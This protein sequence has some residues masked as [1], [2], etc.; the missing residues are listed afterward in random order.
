MTGSGQR[1]VQ[2]HETAR[3]DATPA[4]RRDALRNRQLLLDAAWVLTSERGLDVSYEEIAHAAGT[5]VGTMYRRFPDR[6]DLLDALFAEHVM[7][8]VDL[9]TVAQQSD[10][11]WAG[12]T[13]FLEAQ[14]S[15]EARHQG[16]GQLLRGRHR[17]T[18]VV[19]QAHAAMTPVISG[20]VDRAITAG[21]LPTGVSTAD[22]AAVHLM[23]G[24][25]LDASPVDAR[26]NAP[27]TPIAPWRRA[28]AVA[29]A[30][31]QHADLPGKRPNDTAVDEMYRSEPS[32]LYNAPRKKV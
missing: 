7:Q 16:L 20:L 21:Q 6:D 9:A 5:G 12:I 26:A 22:V 13:G 3:P 1:Q 8:V 24:S 31:L 2:A 14:L 25:V 32:H 4:L 11:A 30:G 23:V 17:P 19:A 15:M 28:L 27:K 10:D 18:A 29:L